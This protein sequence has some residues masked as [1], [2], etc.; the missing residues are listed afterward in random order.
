[1]V[2]SVQAEGGT[3]KKHVSHDRAYWFVFAALGVLTVIELSLP[4]LFRESR[5]VMIV[6]LL[7]VAVV[8]ALGVASYYMHLKF[9]PKMLVWMA[10]GPLVLSFALVMLI[11]ADVN[12]VD[13]GG[14]SVSEPVA[15]ASATHGEAPR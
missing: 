1:M 10:A 2:T 11:K 12:R 9:E 4:T 8:K 6:A 7:T 13:A 15:E 5:G 14:W 3:H